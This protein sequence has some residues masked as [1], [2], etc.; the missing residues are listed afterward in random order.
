MEC[1]GGGEIPAA[2]SDYVNVFSKRKAKTL[3]P[4]RVTDHSIE[5]EPGI[6][7]NKLPYGRIYNLSETELKALKEYIEINLSNGFIRRSTSQ[8]AAPILFIKKKDGSLR[9]CVDFRALNKITVKN[10]YPLPLISE[11]LDHVGK[12]KIFMK[13]DL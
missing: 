6:E 13:L 7:G 8:T 2:Y 9:L 12:A 3:P 1:E 10:C 11:M 5:F 4:H